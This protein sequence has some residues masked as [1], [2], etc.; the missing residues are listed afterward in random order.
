MRYEPSIVTNIINSCVILINN[1]I[2]HDE[3]IT[4]REET[5]EPTTNQRGS[6]FAAGMENRNWMVEYLY[7]SPQQL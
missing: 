1:N 7:Q 2:D 6:L 4:V 5:P 3:F